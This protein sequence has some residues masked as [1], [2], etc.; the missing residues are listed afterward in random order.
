M[1]KKNLVSRFAILFTTEGVARWHIEAKQSNN[2]PFTFAIY[3][4]PV[5]YVNFMIHK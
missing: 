1:G 3:Y 4:M 2:I 5:V